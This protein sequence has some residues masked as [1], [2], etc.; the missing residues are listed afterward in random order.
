MSGYFFIAPKLQFCLVETKSNQ[1]A[2]QKTTI[3]KQ[4]EKETLLLV[5]INHC[6]SVILTKRIAL[7]Q[8]I[9][10]GPFPLAMWPMQKKSIVYSY[11]ELLRKAPAEN[12]EGLAGFTPAQI[13]A[14]TSGR[15]AL[16]PPP[17]PPSPPPSPPPDNDSAEETP[18]DLRR[19]G[20]N[21]ELER[22]R[23]DISGYR[24]DPDRN[25]SNVPYD[26]TEDPRIPLTHGQQMIRFKPFD[27]DEPIFSRVIAEYRKQRALLEQQG[28]LTDGKE[29][30]QNAILG[31]QHAFEIA[32][33]YA[34]WHARGR[35][36]L[37]DLSHYER[38]IVRKKDGS[39]WEYSPELFDPENPASLHPNHVWNFYDNLVKNTSRYPM[40]RE[41]RT[42]APG[43]Y[44]ISKIREL[45]Q[46][47]K[48]QKNGT[49][50]SLE[51]F[52]MPPMVREF[53]E[54]GAQHRLLSRISP[55]DSP[56][57]VKLQTADE[58]ISAA[59][60]RTPEM[61]Q[62]LNKPK[63]NEME[64]KEPTLERS[65]KRFRKGE[66]MDLDWQL[67]RMLGMSLQEVRRRTEPTRIDSFGRF[68]KATL[69]TDERNIPVSGG[70]LP[71][72]TSESGLHWDS[73]TNTMYDLTSQKA[74]S[75]MGQITSPEQAA[76]F[77]QWWFNQ[78]TVPDE[79]QAG[80][81][82]GPE[83]VSSGDSGGT[84]QRADDF[85]RT[86]APNQDRSVAAV[87]PVVKPVVKPDGINLTGAALRSRS[88]MGP[89]ML[90]A[91]RDAGVN[92]PGPKFVTEDGPDAIMPPG[93]LAAEQEAQVMGTRKMEMNSPPKGYIAPPPPGD[94]DLY[95]GGREIEMNSPQYTPENMGTRRPE[96]NQQL[97]KPVNEKLKDNEPTLERS[98]KRFRKADDA[99][100]GGTAKPRRTNP[101]MQPAGPKAAPTALE[102][103]GNAI[104]S[105]AKKVG[106]FLSQ[107]STSMKETSRTPDQRAQARSRI[108]QAVT[109]PKNYWAGNSSVLQGKVKNPRPPITEYTGPLAEDPVRVA[110]RNDI[111]SQVENAPFKAKYPHSV[112]QD[113]AFLAQQY[114]DPNDRNRI[115][116]YETPDFGTPAPG[117]QGLLTLPP[118]DYY[119]PGG[120]DRWKNTGAGG[121]VQKSSEFRMQIEDGAGNVVRRGLTAE[122]YEMIKGLASVLRISEDEV[123]RRLEKNGI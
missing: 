95:A 45:G 61:N 12:L 1:K 98:M 77:R 78:N 101:Y 59:G 57:P 39:N 6:K 42:T 93:R 13:E 16:R 36:P 111:A 22:D 112:M 34:N 31:S 84:T 28:L 82:T 86:R 9:D 65:M 24:Y 113:S 58:M 52:P 47:I 81:G 74:V 102:S 63:E 49:Y 91:Q 71:S 76:Y 21:P 122:R 54:I 41:G 96:M 10:R 69:E 115:P 87:K 20:V 50:A 70:N 97:N 120:E 73:A 121:W 7:M 14:L 33:E 64:E 38:P 46:Q 11:E 88:T 119:E 109:D 94:P 25:A 35:G 40:H 2:T 43:D 32:K 66:T 3:E 80:R 117:R 62:P 107:P 104:S 110:N 26:A 44:D 68:S 15:F 106:N 118:P 67:S 17:S 92:N 29:Y 114:P 99:G 100:E 48:D 103:V 89:D 105:G 123:L 60:T 75:Q 83:R 90:D 56:P 116:V 51:R 108:A 72:S 55:E 23:M 53:A 30:T 19:W 5:I 79:D 85:E 37:P 27:E 18:P 8:R 4:I